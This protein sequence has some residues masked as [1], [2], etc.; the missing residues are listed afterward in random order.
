MIVETNQRR[1]IMRFEKLFLAITLA[2][3]FAFVTPELKAA[4]TSD[5]NS[6]ILKSVTSYQA[7]NQDDDRWVLVF[8]DGR[9]WLV[10]YSEDGS[11]IAEIPYEF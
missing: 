7:V 6:P 10:L 11:I 9:W 3:S 4:G 5:I 1:K 2:V 8:K